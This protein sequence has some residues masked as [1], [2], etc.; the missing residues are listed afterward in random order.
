MISSCMKHSRSAH[1]RPRRSFEQEFFGDD[2]PL[3]QGALEPLGNCA[4][5]LALMP[6]MS[7][8]ELLDVRRNGRSIEQARGAAR[9]LFGRC[10]HG[11]IPIA[12]CAD[13]VTVRAA[14]REGN[15]FSR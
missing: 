1:S 2:P 15:Y 11:D 6:G 9:G 5:Q 4:A 12:E 14:Q 13:S 10:Q 8:D 3:H 7:F